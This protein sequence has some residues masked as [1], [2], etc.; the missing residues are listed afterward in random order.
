[1]LAD[2]AE[3][4]TRTTIERVRLSETDSTNDEAFR[5]AASGEGGPFWLTADRQTG[6]RGRRG[7]S[8]VSNEGNLFATL[9]YPVSRLPEPIGVLP[10]VSALAVR[11]T[12][13]RAVGDKNRI[14]IKWPNDV[15]CDGKKMS[16]ILIEQQQLD[17]CALVAIGVGINITSRPEIEN[18]P[19]ACLAEFGGDLSANDVWA[20]L[21]DNFEICFST[22]RGRDGFSG[23]RAEW[24]RHAAGLGETIIIAGEK[25]SKAGI[26][27][28]LDVNGYLV[29]QN[30]DGRT[31]KISTGDVILRKSEP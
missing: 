13:S 14:T 15:L 28:T 22:W 8:W 5:R 3:S 18:Y 19:T 27:T 1:M 25:S 9:V 16:G 6:G 11:N 21:A 10:L 30:K 4:V 2:K 20:I 12:I 24:L 29:L 31:E 26:F 23:I 17:K 7:R